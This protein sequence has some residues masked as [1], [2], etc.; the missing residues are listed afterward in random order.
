MSR[1]CS[2]NANARILL[3]AAVM[4]LGVWLAGLESSRRELLSAGRYASEKSA[5]ARLVSAEA[6]PETAGAACLWEPASASSPLQTDQAVAGTARKT[7]D[8]SQRKPI[9][10]IRDPYSAFSAV[11]VDHKHNEVIL[12]DENL[13]QIAVY[14]RLANTPASAKM[15][16]P[17][18]LI[19]GDQTHIEFQCGVYVDPMTGDIYAVNN[20]TV[21]DMVIFSREA[22]GNVPPTRALHTPHGTFGIA[23][24]EEREEL[25]LTVQHDNAIV[26]YR[27]YADGEEPPIRLLQGD[28]TLLADPHGIA[29]DERRG[30]LFV[31][32]YGAT[33]SYEQA[34][35]SRGPAAHPNWPLQ[36]ASP[37][38]GRF[39]PPSIN[40]YKLDDQ[41][42]A[43]PQWQITGPRTRLNWATGLAIDE[44]RNELL[45]ANDMNDEILV[46]ALDAR[47]D[48]APVRT[49]KGPRTLLKNPTGLYLDKINNEFWV[50]NFGNRT[51]TVYKRGADGDVPPLRVIRSGPID[52]VPMLGNPHPVAYDTKREQILVPN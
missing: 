32:N 10:M 14:D 36:D 51:A 41:G 25:F 29:I 45:V 27:K 12:A 5:A 3:A 30:L 46:F 15:T 35:P 43:A 34:R 19:S 40:V 33:K 26:V 11:A 42:D 18:R 9:R 50:T 47:G 49:M 8:L 44:D 24:H 31:T 38:T 2:R 1:L 6:L 7:L 21:D 13:F 39:Y 52:N 20:D 23:V 37:G 48:A 4:G 28:R 22:R 16:E 17:K